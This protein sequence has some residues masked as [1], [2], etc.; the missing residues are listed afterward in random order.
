[1][2]V[3]NMIVVIRLWCCGIQFDISFYLLSYSQIVL[4]MRWTCLKVHCHSRLWHH[5]GIV[6]S[7]LW[8][9]CSQPLWWTAWSMEVVVTLLVAGA[10]LVIVVVEE[11][12]SMRMSYEQA[13]NVGDVASLML[14]LL[15]AFRWT[16]SRF[17]AS[18][19]CVCGTDWCIFT[20][21]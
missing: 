5:E 21:V 3:W 7:C 15:T 13:S 9:M 17:A 18:L 11:E 4:W 16:V 8:R 1:M 14:E 19:H 20:V 6:C 12:F 10:W 2:H